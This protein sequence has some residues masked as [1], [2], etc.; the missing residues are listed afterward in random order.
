MAFP[1]G[2][3]GALDLK[4]ATIVS[5]PLVADQAV[6]ESSCV[7]YMDKL[8]PTINRLRAVDAVAGTAMLQQFA[9]I[10]ATLRAGVEQC[11]VAYLATSTVYQLRQYWVRFMCTFLHDDDN[12]RNLSCAV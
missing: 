12:A 11:K 4:S 1:S 2:V 6:Y 7:G 3:G 9:F 10:G 5:R 8:L